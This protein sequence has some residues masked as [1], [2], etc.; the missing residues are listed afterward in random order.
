MSRARASQPLSIVAAILG[1]LTAAGHAEKAPVAQLKSGDRIALCGDSITE[2]GGYS[3]IVGTYLIACQSTPDLNYKSFGWAGE[4]AAGFRKR[5]PVT[6]LP[7]K[8][9]VVTVL[10]GMNDGNYKEEDQATVERFREN[11][12]DSVEQLKAAGVRQIILSGPTPVDPIL[13]DRTAVK[14]NFNVTAEQYNQ[15]LAALANSAQE[16]ATES[17]ITYIPLQQPLLDLMKKAK[18]KYGEDYAVVGDDGFHPAQNG[19]LLIAEL[20]LKAMGCR[21]DIGTFTLDMATGKASA[22]PGHRILSSSANALEVES[23]RYPFCFIGEP[24]AVGR[25]G[26]L[27]EFSAFN[28]DLNRFLL[29][30]ANP[31]ADRLKVTWGETNRVFSA[32]E[33]KEGINLA[34]AFPVS[35]P[36]A[37]P[38]YKLYWD[39]R[40]Q[41]EEANFQAMKRLWSI[42]TKLENLAADSTEKPTLEAEVAPLAQ[43]ISTPDASTVPPVTHR[44]SIEPAT[45]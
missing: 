6:I 26:A 22:S 23:T 35:N 41:N 33:L 20:L 7:Y 30:V 44:I 19:G 24:G 13:F 40:K 15:T 38:F 16:V 25:N 1:G 11:I 17:Q 45:P 27:L 4:T 36:F 32:N 37:K 10:Y 28:K 9:N 29:V 3:A 43:K 18:E 5:L 21:G 2:Y 8:P 14:R 12:Q 39:L 42:T 34:E 31:P